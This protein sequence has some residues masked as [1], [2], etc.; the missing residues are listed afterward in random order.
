M[1]LPRNTE[2]IIVADYV[3]LLRNA[4]AFIVADSGKKQNYSS[5]ITKQSPAEWLV[6]YC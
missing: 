4:E 1:L 6:R 3:R 2:A 5:L